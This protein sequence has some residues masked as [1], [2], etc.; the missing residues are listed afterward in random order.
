MCRSRRHLLSAP[1]LASGCPQIGNG[2]AS[3]LGTPDAVSSD[4]G[5]CVLG[6]TGQGSA[7]ATGIHDQCVS[8]YGVYDMVGNVWEWID[9]SISDG[10]YGN[11]LLP[12]DG[13]VAEADA[14]GV[15]SKTG[16]SSPAY[17]ND[18]F[19]VDKTGVKGMFRGGFWST[20]EKGG[21]FSINATIPTSFIGVASGFRCVRDAQ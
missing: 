14:D 21:I 6:R 7:D 12:D 19:F 2:T 20:A 17:G 8:S 1:R 13:Y 10:M 18:Y 15:A 9:A 16:T 11:R 3:A 4:K 5:A